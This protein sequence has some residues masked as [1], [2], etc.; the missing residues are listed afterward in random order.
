VTANRAGL[1]AV[2]PLSS[3]YSPLL[4]AEGT[5]TVGQ[6]SSP[7]IHLSNNPARTTKR[8]Y[9]SIAR[10]PPHH[11]LKFPSCPVRSARSSPGLIYHGINRGNAGNAIFHKDGDYSAFLKILAQARQ[12]IPI[13]IL[14]Y[15]LM[16]NHWHLVLRPHQ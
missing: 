4:L 15:Y 9:S 8:A 1:A 12:R 11:P 5:M 13:D 2:D 3:V 7:A 6:N 10:S 16:P 14:A